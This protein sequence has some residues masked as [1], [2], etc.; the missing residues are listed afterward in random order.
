MVL[1]DLLHLYG[2]WSALDTKVFWDRERWRVEEWI[3]FVMLYGLGGM[4]ITFCAGVGLGENMRR[5]RM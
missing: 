1:C 5:K 3:N 4:R 2:I